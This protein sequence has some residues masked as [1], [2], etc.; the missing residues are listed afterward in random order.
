M[1][2]GFLFVWMLRL[3]PLLVFSIKV[4][5]EDQIEKP[6]IVIIFSDDQ[7]YGDLGCYGNN[8][9]RTP[10]IDK[11]AS[12]GMLFTD[13]YMAAAVCTPS[14]AALLTGSYPQRVGL[15]S[16]LFP[17]N[18]SGGQL[19]GMAL[20]LNPKEITVAELLKSAGYNTACIGKWHLGDLPQFMPLNHG[21]DEYFGLPYSNDML[22]EN[23]YHNFDSLPLY[24]GQKIIEKNPNQDSLVKRYTGKAKDFIKKNKDRP[25]FLYL[26]HNMPHR[27]CHASPEFIPN[28]NFSEKQLA[29][30]HGEN[31]ESRDFL[32]PATIEELDWS[33]GEILKTLKKQNL[34]S[35]T[36]VIFTSDNG[37]AVG[38]SGV[39]KGRK[40]SM[41]E[42]GL[43]VPCIMSWKGTV[44]AGT[45]CS[46]IAASIDL[47]PTLANLANV[48][49]PKDR[50]IDGIDITDYVLGNTGVCLR[51]DFFYLDQK[52]GLK[53]IRNGH[54]KLFPGKKPQL[55]DLDRDVSEQ[56]NVAGH[57]PE[58][59]DQLT[60]RSTTFEKQLN[61]QKRE[62]G[63]FPVPEK[64]K[65]Y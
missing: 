53:A 65:K 15:P 36:L 8:A 41:N 63:L 19:N 3:V 55:Y 46:Q 40:G 56:R 18:M 26:A 9:L 37:P 60:Q 33:V 1:K 34:E 51:R 39:L 14:R 32:Y 10:N 61:N 13:F 21:F 30:I 20:G 38:S 48:D 49:I 11:M 2:K 54:W 7:G 22:P 47:Y 24:D 28:H 17:N 23:L 29:G 4:N 58:I 50:M 6:N 45:V 5:G 57:Y 35:N 44:P 12:E 52:K 31:K 59:V 62:P 25:F 16:V 42:G 43:R 64:T 27:P